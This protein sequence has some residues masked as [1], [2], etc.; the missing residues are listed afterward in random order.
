M[1]D[2]NP[3]TY[4]VQRHS[5][6]G[7]YRGA[8]TPSMIFFLDL[9]SFFKCAQI[10]MKNAEFSEEGIFKRGNIQRRNFLSGEFAIGGNLH[11]YTGYIYTK[12]NHAVKRIMNSFHQYVCDNVFLGH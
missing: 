3:K 10:Y 6:S 11:R 2:P 4:G 1:R 12:N 5:P 8:K 9:N 7:G